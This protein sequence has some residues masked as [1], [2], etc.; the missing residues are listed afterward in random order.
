M[1]KKKLSRDQKRKQ[2]KRKRKKQKKQRPFLGRSKR[3]T[4][5]RTKTEPDDAQMIKILPPDDQPSEADDPQFARIMQIL[6]ADEEVPFVDADTLPTY[7]NY[8]EEHLQLP[9]L[10]K[11]IESIGYFGWEERFQFGYGTKAE[12]ERIRQ[13]HSSL[14]D[15]FELNA[16]EGEIEPEWDMWANIR[17]TSDGKRFTIPLS[18]LEAVDENSDNAVMLNDYTVWIVNWR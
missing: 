11:G 16:L 6:G 10:V 12:Y 3:M 14:K 4:P 18:E 5:P 8:L 17:R 9:C 1:A 2:K 7:L 13:E 15:E